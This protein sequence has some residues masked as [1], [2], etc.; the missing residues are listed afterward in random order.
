MQIQIR[1]TLSWTLGYGKHTRVHI[2]LKPPLFLM[3]CIPHNIQSYFV[4][5]FFFFLN[6][7]IPVLIILVTEKKETQ[8]QTCVLFSKERF[9]LF[10]FFFL[11]ESPINIYKVYIFVYIFI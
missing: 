11:K 9:W 6:T 7:K 2:A 4:I 1:C 3:S 10:W 8:V 5:F